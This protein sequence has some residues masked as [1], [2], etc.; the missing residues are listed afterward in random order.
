M[1]L[2]MIRTLF[3]GIGIPCV[4][5]MVT[6]AYCP[7]CGGTRA[8][9][10]LITGHILQSLRYNPVVCYGAAA[11]LIFGLAWLYCRFCRRPGPGFRRMEIFLYGGLVLALVN[12]IYKNYMLLVRGVDLL[13]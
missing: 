4:F 11:A 7:G 3:Q 6:G 12:C 13:A 9:K 8:A 2:E 5:H 10:A 1:M